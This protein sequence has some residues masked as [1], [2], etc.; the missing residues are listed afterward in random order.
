MLNSLKNNVNALSNLQKAGLAA[1]LVAVYGGVLALTIT[2]SRPTYGVLY[3]KLSLEDASAIKTRLQER[4]ISFKLESDRRGE[5]IQI[6]ADQVAGTR[7]DLARMDLPKGNADVG[8]E[9]FDKTTCDITEPVQKINTR[10]AIEGELSRT[11]KSLTG[12]KDARVHIAMPVKAVASKQAED[13][14]AAVTIHMLK[15]YQLNVKQV[16]GIK[17]IVASS[18]ER[19]TPKKV[20]ILDSKGNILNTPHKD[21]SLAY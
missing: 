16:I 10:R 6:P 9:I 5:T 14:K 1:I 13:G 15:G 11:I 7:L 2:S 18:V 3:S 21:P 8:N 17:Y 20:I 12:V 4:N 19:L